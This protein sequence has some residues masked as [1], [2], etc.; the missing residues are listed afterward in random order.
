M[1][2]NE[3]YAQA[4]V[5]FRNAGRDGKA[6]MCDAYLLQQKAG[7][8]STTAS[9]DRKK[10]FVNAANTFLSCVQNSQQVRGERLTCYQAAADCFYG[11]RDPKS[12]GDNYQLAELYPK[13]ACVYREGGYFDEMV[14]VI[15]RYEDTFTDD[16]RKKMMMDAQVHYFKV[17]SNRRPF[18]EHP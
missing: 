6:K 5:A 1:F 17:Y 7:L 14:E 2:N 15:T 4:S 3:R 12:A 11:A 16:L 18:L 13:A 9:S 8:I 10:A